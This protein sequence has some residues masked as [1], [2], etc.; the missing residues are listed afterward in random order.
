MAK[1]LL[2]NDHKII[3]K[4]EVKKLVSQAWFYRV[5]LY[6]LPFLEYLISSSSRISSQQ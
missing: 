1:K 4:P 6:H 2:K 5:F 3:I